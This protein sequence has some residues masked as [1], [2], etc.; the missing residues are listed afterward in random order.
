VAQRLGK[1]PEF[2]WAAHRA[3]WEG[4]R[5]I[6]SVETVR[7]LAGEVGLPPDAVA[8]APDDPSVR[9]E[10]AEALLRAYR[11]HVFGVPF[12]VK[13]RERFWGVDRLE[14]FL[15]AMEGRPYRYVAGGALGPEVAEGD[16]DLPDHAMRAVGAY[17]QDCAGGCG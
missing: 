12:F 7:E 13:G 9:R 14:G 3:R 2:F 10:G 4:G 15:S 16:A 11:D 5:N 6:W 17:D 8:C 1:G